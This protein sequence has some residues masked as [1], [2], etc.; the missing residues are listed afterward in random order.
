MFF[1]IVLRGLQSGGWYPFGQTQTPSSQN[2]GFGQETQL[3][4]SS[5]RIKTTTIKTN[6]NNKKITK[7]N[8]NNNI[9]TGRIER[10]NRDL[11]MVKIYECLQ[12]MQAI[13]Y[14]IHLDAKLKTN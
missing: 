10:T 5:V 11:Y 8:N 9:Y 14:L 3:Q 2:C 6:K 12:D 7:K 1:L 13:S 4:G